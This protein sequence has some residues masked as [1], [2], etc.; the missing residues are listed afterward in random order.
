MNGL[1]I[2][3]A[4]AL[5]LLA[6]LI[7]DRARTGRAL[8]IAVR[9]FAGLLPA[10]LAMLAAVSVVLTLV[11]TETIT[12]TLGGEDLG[13][14]TAAGALIG[15]VALMP[16]FVAFPLGGVLLERGVAP[17]VIAAFT[18]SLM[19]VGVLTYPVERRVLGARVAI[20]RN[21]LGMLV[22]LAVAVAIGL[23]FGD[24]P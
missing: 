23:V 16:G 24:L 19:M 9:R 5:A 17:M 12:R 2:T 11:P 21:V 10:F 8:V 7:A 13:L 4:A 18:T 1:V 22:A 20:V 14:A 3:L 6:S 15:S